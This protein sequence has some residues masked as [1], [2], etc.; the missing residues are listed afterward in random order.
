M[1]LTVHFVVTIER[2]T[3][4]ELA[5]LFRD[6]MWKLHRLPKSVI[7]DREP[8]FVAKLT[9]EL[10]EIL[11]IETR[12]LTVFHPQTD[13]QTE[14][15]NQELEQYLKFFMEYRQRD[16]LEWLAIAEFVVNNKVHMAIKVLPFMANYSREL[17]IGTDIRR[18]E[19]VEKVTEFAERIKRVQVKAKAVFK[20]V[21]ENI[22]RQANREQREVEK[23]KKG[24]KV[25]LSTK[26]LVFKERLVNK[27]TERYMKLYKIEDVVSKNAVKLK[28]LTLM[29]THPVV[30]VSRIE[31]YREPVRGQKVKELKLVEVDEVEE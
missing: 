26:D 18:K 20:K 10:N 11:R 9:R 21:Q 1:I 31:R 29:R 14:Q 19:K 25:M 6:N 17:R 12:L 23:W 15:I 2:V 4:E 13:E 27:L 16:W 3:A 7:S 30:N 8:Q 5:R 28:L 24:N 22:K